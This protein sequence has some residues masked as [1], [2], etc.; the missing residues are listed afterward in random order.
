[1]EVLH[2]A[3]VGIISARAEEQGAHARAKSAA[4]GQRLDLIGLLVMHEQEQARSKTLKQRVDHLPRGSGRHAMVWGGRCWGGRPD[5]GL[6]STRGHLDTH[7][8]AAGHVLHVGH[9]GTAASV[10][11]LA[12]ARTQAI[13]H[14]ID[15]FRWQPSDI[16]PGP[17]AKAGTKGVWQGAYKGAELLC[18][19]VAPPTEPEP[20]LNRKW[21]RGQGDGKCA[22]GAL[23]AHNRRAEDAGIKQA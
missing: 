2:T 16:E 8:S 5:G 12:C 1:M 4:D 3:C 15:R 14:G 10:Q 22:E 21:G 23:R 17:L 6:D 9:A 18:T 20:A 11:S 7:R 13:R 19:R